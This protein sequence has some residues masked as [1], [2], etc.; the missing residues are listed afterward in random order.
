[1]VVPTLMRTVE[2]AATLA[3]AALGAL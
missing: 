1:V 2:D 3:K